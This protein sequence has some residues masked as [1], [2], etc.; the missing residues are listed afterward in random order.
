VEEVLKTEM[1]LASGKE[2]ASFTYEELVQRR[3]KAMRGSASLEGCKSLV[4][5]GSEKVAGTKDR[6]RFTH[7]VRINIT[8]PFI[9]LT[10]EQSEIVGRGIKCPVC[11]IKGE[12]GDDY[13]P[14]EDFVKA[15]ENVRKTNNT[16]LVEYHTVPGTHHFFMNSPELVAPII[17]KFLD[18]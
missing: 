1:A 5:R 9:M 12:P 18:S 4:N 13:E 8:L 15:I 17:N 2:R 10:K 6:Y 14:R 3:L 7:D 11:V 16:S